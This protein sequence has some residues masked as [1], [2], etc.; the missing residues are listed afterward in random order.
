M[1]KDREKKV[2]A[3]S[4]FSAEHVLSHPAPPSV[5]RAVLTTHWRSVLISGRETAIQQLIPLTYF[6]G[7]WVNKMTPPLGKGEKSLNFLKILSLEIYITVTEDKRYKMKT[8][9]KSK[10][11]PFVT[12][13]Y[14]IS[15]HGQEGNS[16]YRWR[17]RGSKIL[18]TCVL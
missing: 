17:P 18:G 4:I 2:W 15:G 6:F 7:L 8:I 3:E 11:D 1:R 16:A 12:E 13:T 10:A 9:I 5:F 14:L